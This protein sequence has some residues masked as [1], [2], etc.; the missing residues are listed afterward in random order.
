LR[1]LPNYSI[2]IFDFLVFDFLG[3]VDFNHCKHNDNYNV[4]RIAA[5]VH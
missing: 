1:Y 4:D 5:V 2:I 3:P